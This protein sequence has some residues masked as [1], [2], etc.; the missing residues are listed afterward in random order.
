MEGSGDGVVVLREADPRVTVEFGPLFRKSDLDADQFELEDSDNRIV[1]ETVAIARNV[2]GVALLADDS[3]PIR[4]ARQAGL[5]YERPLAEWRR[6]EGPDE[7][8]IEIV[9]LKREIGAQPILT[10][11]VTGAS[12]QNRLVIEDSPDT[13]EEACSKAFAEAVAES[14]PQTSRESLVK[15]HGL[16]SPGPYDFGISLHGTPGLTNSQL[17][18][19]DKE[20]QRFMSTSQKVAEIL[21]KALSQLGFARHINIDVGNDGDRAAEKVLVEA[22]VSAPFQFL[23]TNSISKQLKSMLEAPTPPKPSRG[24]GDLSYRGINLQDQLG[25]P[26]IDIFHDLDQPKAGDQSTYVSW[27]REG[28]AKER[29]S[30]FRFLL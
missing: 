2:P 13:A 1:A 30:T 18:Q 23:P 4:L 16:Y 27:R 3:K 26:R 10:L 28:Y 24:I 19:Y 22:R 17:E 20:Y 21:H 29:I 6:Q 25:P 11:T 12:T 15:R 5:P 14:Q 8:D 9:D 7:R